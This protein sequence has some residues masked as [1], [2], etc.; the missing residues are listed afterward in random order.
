M[1]IVPAAGVVSHLLG[2]SAAWPLLMF[3]VLFPVSIF[4]HEWAHALCAFRWSAR[5]SQDVTP[6]SGWQVAM[7]VRP[8]LPVRFDLATTFA[9][10]LA[11]AMTAAPL[12]VTALMGS[13]PEI[14]CLALTVPFAA[15]LLALAP[16]AP[17]GRAVISTVRAF[18]NSSDGR[19]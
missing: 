9:G 13:S 2:A 19:S 7:I 6:I 17:D 16:I 12:A 4:V 11:G 3:V 10:P 14:E 18:E 5:R 1:T 8:V 15:H